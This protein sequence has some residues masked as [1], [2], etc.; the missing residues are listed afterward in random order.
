MLLP[1]LLNL[2]LPTYGEH[3]LMTMSSVYPG[4]H[5]TRTLGDVLIGTGYGLVD[6]AVGGFLFA[7]L[8]NFIAG[9][10]APLV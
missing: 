10:T 2:V 7:W 1:G 8:Y 6:G 3:F 4:Y 5:A 9:K